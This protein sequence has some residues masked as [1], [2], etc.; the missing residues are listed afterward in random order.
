MSLRLVLVLAWTLPCMPVQ[1]VFLTRPGLAKVRFAQIYWRGVAFIMGLRITVKGEISPERPI[2]FIA[3]HCTWLDIVAL[4]AVLPGCFVAKADIARWPFISWI[5]KLG[6]TVFVSRNKATVE[7][8]RDYLAARLAA[9]DNI[10]LFPEGT[11]SDGRRVLPFQSSFLAI[12]Q[13]SSKPVIQPVTIVYDQLDGLPVQRWDRPVISWYGDMDIASHY[14][15]IGKRTSLG[16]TVI[17][18][19]AIPAGTFANRKILSNALEARLAGN[20]ARLRQGRDAGP[21]EL[22]P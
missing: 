10:I 12:A 18:D 7:R 17:I 3:N 5:A 19:P 20:A 9:G 13:A 16:A 2:I 22:A 4:G 8:E 6:R 11:T 21:K 1:A 15:G 14:P